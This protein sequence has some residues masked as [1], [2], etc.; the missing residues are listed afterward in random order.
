MNLP[1]LE[2][3]ILLRVKRIARRRGKSKTWISKRFEFDLKRYKAY[4][5]GQSAKLR[6]IYEEMQ[7]QMQGHEHAE[8]EVHT[9]DEDS[10]T[11]GHST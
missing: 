3:G 7:R 9:H 5:Q 6:E 1:L 11:D 8:G 2:A 10:D 4:Q